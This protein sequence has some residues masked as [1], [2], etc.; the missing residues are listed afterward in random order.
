M[1]DVIACLISGAMKKRPDNRI[2]E[3]CFFAADGAE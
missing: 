3:A 2:I 1:P